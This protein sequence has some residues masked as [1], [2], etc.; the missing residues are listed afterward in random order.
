MSRFIDLLIGLIAII[1]ILVVQTSGAVVSNEL[2]NEFNENP[3]DSFNQ[4]QINND[5]YTAV[6]K[7]VPTVALM[8]V[9]TLIVFR[10]YRRQRVTAMRRRGL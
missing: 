10:E 3:D 5:L 1:G 8:G 6:A 7:W 9:L 2:R 4:K